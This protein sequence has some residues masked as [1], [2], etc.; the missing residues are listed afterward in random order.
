MGWKPGQ[1][2]GINSNGLKVPLS[3]V[4]LMRSKHEG[5]GYKSSELKNLQILEQIINVLQLNIE[6]GRCRES[7]SQA[8]FSVFEE[9]SDEEVKHK[10][11]KSEIAVEIFNYEVIGLVDS[12]S[13]I[14]CISEEFWNEVKQNGPSNIPMLPIKPFQIRT[15]VGHKSVEV[16]NIV[17]LPLKLGTKIFDTGTVVVPG[18]I[19]NL[20]L[21]FD[22]LKEN[23][24]V[25]SLKKNERGLLFNSD[26]GK[27][28]IPFHDHEGED[29]SNKGLVIRK[30]L[31]GMGEQELIE[32]N[33]GLDWLLNKYQSIF[34]L[35]LGRA[36]CYQHEIVMEPHTPIVKRTYPIPYAYRGKVEEKL[37]EMETQGIISRAST[38]YCS[39]LTFT[40]KKD[41][42]IR[43]LLDAREINK[44]M[45]AET[46]KPPLQLDVMNSFHGANYISVID[47]NNA[48]FQIEI[49]E[50]SRKYTGFSFNGKSY[51]YNVLPQGLK[52]SVGSFSRAMDVILGHEVRE[53][54]VN[55]LDDLAIITTGDL[56][57]H[58][59]HL[60]IVLGKLRAA[61]LTCNLEKC[62][63]LCK[64]VKMLGYVIS[65]DGL[66]TDTDKVKAI[67]EFPVPRKTKHLRA[68]LGLCN[69]YRR[70]IPNY[71][72]Y[73]QP[74]CELLKKETN[75]RW[76]SKE[77]LA[78]DKVKSLFINT[79]QLHHPDFSK[80]YYLE[81][82]SSGIGLAGVLYQ[83]D[84][85][86][87]KK[88]MGFHSKA[89]RGAQLNWTVTEQEF[90][91]IINCLE[92]FETYLR[93]TKVIIKS[94]HKALTFIKTWKLYNARITRWV[95]Y[96]ENFQYEIHHI[97]GSENVVADVL[98]RY[99][100]ES[101][102]LQEE[103]VKMPEILYMETAV[104]RDLI[105]KLK[106]LPELQKEDEGIREIL[107]RMQTGESRSDK[108]DKMVKRS[109]IINDTLYIQRGNELK[110]VIYLPETL[111]VE[112]INQVHMEMGHQG[113][114]KVLKYIR[115]RFFWTGMTRRVKQVIK[116]CHDCQVTKSETVKYVGPCRSIITENIGDLVMVDLYGPLP[117][118]LFGMS[119]V[120]VIQD[121]FSKF[122]KFYGLR[123][124]TT[125]SVLT[126]M[127]KFF[128][129]I[130]P[131]AIM[132]D[133]GSQ[134]AS[135][136]WREGLKQEGI[137]P[138]YTTV[139]NPR[140]NT[141]E[142][143]NKE[144]G[145]LFRTYCRQN[146]KGWT[147][148]LPKLEEL[149]NNTYHESTKFTPCEILYGEQTTLSFDKVIGVGDEQ[150]DVERIRELVRKNLSVAGEKRRARFNQR[151][152]L[153]NYQIGD[154][155]KIR[156]LNK[157]DATQKLT[158]KFSAL[159][160][161]PYLVAGNPYHN[162][163]ILV[164]P[165][166]N[167]IRG[168]YNTIHLSRYY[169]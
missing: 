122:V 51:V 93:G 86:G 60:D 25:I 147:S 85:E 127:R 6:Q 96:L 65:T 49:S 106:H 154:L 7:G 71:S 146:H 2:L 13:E 81:T 114:Y 135:K 141:T 105:S 152:R 31:E 168:K 113:A 40:L 159:Y 17:L 39:P 3:G 1:T 145:R 47:L 107:Q 131:T 77:Q 151:Y 5:L 138:I 30:E 143:V 82:D 63:F 59:E 90:Y 34:S 87:E 74:L 55:Y 15:A 62:N 123:K 16:R 48:Y 111:R 149:Y 166:T 84:D 104:N 155:V 167:K 132:S 27:Q 153:I 29:G 110:P 134:F 43:V 46:E 100:P 120:L 57:K 28:L 11:C 56:Q 116:V 45:V 164:D 42:T 9:Q 91:A 10:N 97:K 24:I 35:R 158:K 72:F 133:N 68:F 67:Q 115:D 19:N 20:I 32:A 144:L 130:K 102:L 73:T 41:G 4:V 94:D 112:I 117:S 33:E 140:P 88:I 108:V 64:E 37:M 21:G 75:W 83:L 161:G 70:F 38:P 99:P 89:L 103:R 18:L 129:I 165:K 169:K 58:I 53:F 22:W 163:Y 66:Q 98:S 69:F 157:S 109:V 50:A 8:V 26:E 119:Y 95:N 101:D 142:R 92:K 14:T 148:V 150:Q 162:V 137:K 52:T 36:N 79:I 76:G 156:K 125:R 118:G 124:A 126:Q 12:G 139:R 61:G 136:A 121:S 23:E 128:E 44:Y 160:E 80:P 54:C 78:F